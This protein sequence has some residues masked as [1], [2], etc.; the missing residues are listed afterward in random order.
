MLIRG[1]PL[2]FLA[3][4]AVWAAGGSAL[5]G[6]VR[7][8]VVLSA[9]PRPVQVEPGSP[10]AVPSPGTPPGSANADPVLRS[11]SLQELQT[12]RQVV[13]REKDPQGGKAEWKGIPLSRIV[14]RA[15]DGLPTEERAKIDLVILRNDAGVRALVPRYLVTKFPFIV[16][17]HRNGR[18]LESSRGPL[19]SVVPWSSRPEITEE[20]LPLERYFVPGISRIELTNYDQLF[21]SF[22]LKKKGDPVAARGE[23][24]FVR[25]CLSCHG[26]GDERML[27]ELRTRSLASSSHAQ[28]KGFPRLREKDQRA[29][30]S[31]LD[32]YRAEN[33][34]ASAALSS[35]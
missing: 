24:L 4:L 10:Q 8:S 17:T 25:T 32:A 1:I 19:L 23:K 20:E 3:L 35:R 28:V 18:A 6:E 14:D 5:G 13:S 21:S 11:W 9:P 22:Y 15:I 31:Y 7:L 34:A 2:S 16:A 26:A 30:Q 29:V 27:T 33:V 12:F